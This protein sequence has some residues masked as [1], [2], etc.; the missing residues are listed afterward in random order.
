MNPRPVAGK[1]R[2]KMQVSKVKIPDGPGHAVKPSDGTVL[3]GIYEV[4]RQKPE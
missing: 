3:P 1:S 4:R 2:V